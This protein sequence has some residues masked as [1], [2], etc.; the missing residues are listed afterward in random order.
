MDLYLLP[1]NGHFY[2]QTLSFAIITNINLYLT[3][4][5]YLKGMT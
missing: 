4:L 3:L 5:L 2:C 1:T